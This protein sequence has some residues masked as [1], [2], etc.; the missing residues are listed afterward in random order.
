MTSSDSP[1]GAGSGLC[2]AIRNFERLV[3][4]H[5]LKN[6]TPADLGRLRDLLHEL[7]ALVKQSS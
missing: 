3:T 1:A 5:D 6:L 2:E 7:S 4:G